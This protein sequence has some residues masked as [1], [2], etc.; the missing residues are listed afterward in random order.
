MSWGQEGISSEKTYECR[1]VRG[2]DFPRGEPTCD[3]SSVWRELIGELYPAAEFS[4]PADEQ[5]LAAIEKNLG[6]PLPH[7]LSSLLSEVD[8]VRNEYGD[9]VV[10]PA[11]RIL[12]DNL[13][14]RQEPDYLEL[15]A[16]FDLLLFFG[17][18]DMGTQF[19]YVHTDYG[20]G[21]VYWDHESDQRRLVAALL[22]DYLAHCLSEGTGWYR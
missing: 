8:G 13:A 3:D 4:D 9:D 7:E 18:S 6:L 20:P 22:R 21:I 14:M 16:P 11:E 15:Y 19:A 5:T 17:D 12:H 1:A 10:W 2:A